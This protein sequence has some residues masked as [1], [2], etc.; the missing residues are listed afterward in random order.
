MKKFLMITVLAMSLLVTGCGEVNNNNQTNQT[1]NQKIKIGLVGPFSG[2]V[3]SFGQFMNNGLELALNDLPAEER[4]KIEIIKEDDKA[5]GKTAVAGVQKLIEIDRVNYIIGP[6]NNNTVIATEKIFDE[7]KIISLITGLPNEQIANMGEYHF[8]FLLEIGLLKK[9]L[10]EYIKQERKIETIGIIYLNDSFGEEIRNKFKQYYKSLGGVIVSEE[11]FEKGSGDVKT[12]LTKIKASKPQGVFIAAYGN[13]LIAILKELKELNLENLPKFGIH[14]FESPDVLKQVADLAEGVVY[15]Y[16]RA[17]G[18]NRPATV[19]EYIQKHQDKFGYY[20]DVYSTGVYDSFNL[21][22]GAIK[23]C[24]YENKECVREKLAS[25]KDYAGASGLL[26][27][28]E[29]GVAIFDEAGLR[30]VRGGKFEDL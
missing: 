11:S 13:D 14:S 15:P 3:V 12:Q 10:A 30:T 24:G 26:T 28:D 29:R 21:L 6:L 2:P 5:D 9:H 4:Q 23:I 27:V 16:P 8:S 19:E 1:G 17:T 20:P 22:Y 7:N 18:K 25:V